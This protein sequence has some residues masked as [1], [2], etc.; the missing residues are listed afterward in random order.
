MGL[1]RLFFLPVVLGDVLG[2]PVLGDVLGDP[3]L[4]RVGEP[5]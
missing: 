5:A 2:D 3:I 1:V 4:L